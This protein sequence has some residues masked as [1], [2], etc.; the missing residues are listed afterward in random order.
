MRS[1]DSYITSSAICAALLMMQSFANAQTH[2]TQQGGVFCIADID[3]NLSVDGADLGMFLLSWGSS[4]AEA[5]FNFDGEVSG[6]DLGVLLQQWGT[7]CHPFHANVEV[8]IENGFVIVEGNGIPDH[9]MGNFPGECNNPN[10]VIAMDDRWMLPIGPTPT[11][12]PSVDVFL[13][14]GPTGIWVNGL[15]FYN[16]YDGGGIDAPASICFDVCNNH[17][18]PDGRLCINRFLL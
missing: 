15:A 5:D 4:E 8:S 10:N 2:P 7:T 9:D 6:A 14:L 3:R 12:N 11:N 17:P 16:P 13:Q 18:S 1:I